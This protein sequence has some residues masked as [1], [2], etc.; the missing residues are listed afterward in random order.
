MG[1]IS[2]KAV[3]EKLSKGES[4]SVFVYLNRS[5]FF[6]DTELDDGCIGVISSDIGALFDITKMSEDE[7]IEEQIAQAKRLNQPLVRP[8]YQDNE[9]PTSRGVIS[10][11]RLVSGSLVIS[12]VDLERAKKFK[13]VQVVS[14]F[15]IDYLQSMVAEQIFEACGKKIV[16]TDKSDIHDDLWLDSLEAIELVMEIEK[17]IGLEIPDNVVETIFYSKKEFRTIEWLASFLV[18]QIEV[19]EKLVK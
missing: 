1:R 4:F 5:G 11:D 12:V 17:K 10:V 7:V 19:A 8:Q 14:K 15:I 3:K 16:V 6:Y 2:A 18:Q 13:D 9:V